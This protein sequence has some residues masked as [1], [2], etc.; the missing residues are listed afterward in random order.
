MFFII[1]EGIADLKRT[2]LSTFVTIFVIFISL[3]IGN[4]YFFIRTNIDNILTSIEHDFVIEAF[5]VDNAEQEK[6]DKIINNI[7]DSK[8]IETILF[9]SKEKA[10]ETFRKEFKEDPLETIGYNPLPR[11]I[12]IK[13]KEQFTQNNYAK[14]IIKQLQKEVIIDET[15]YSNNLKSMEKFRENS[16]KIE[17]IIFTLISFFSVTLVF[18]T[19]RLSIKH[20][21]EIIRT[22]KLVG[23][24]NFSIRGPFL[25]GGLIQGTIGGILA[26]ITTRYLIV[27]LNTLIAKN[28]FVIFAFTSDTIS[29]R[30][31]L[32]GT[33]LGLVGSWISVNRFLSKY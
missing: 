27:I 30:L 21:K 33:V 26:L 13:L 22:M 17:L 25:I 23:A 19:I 16:V 10:L 12:K 31:I 15:S 32:F 1:K 9:I 24:S 6:I 28:S 18:N 29:L 8:E 2:S 4:L 7:K 11:S 3:L 20:K 5:I 14:K